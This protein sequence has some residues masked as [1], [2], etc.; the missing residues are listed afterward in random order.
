V[1]GK[2]ERPLV[3]PDARI[4]GSLIVSYNESKNVYRKPDSL[5]LGYGYT[6]VDTWL[7][8]NLG[9]KRAIENRAR[10]FVAVRYFDG[11]YLEAPDPIEVRDEIKY[12]DAR[13]V[14]SEFT[15]YRKYFYKTRYVYGFGRTEDIP[16]GISY[17]LTGGYLTLQ[18]L[19]RPYFALKVNAGGANEKGNFYTLNL[20]TG[21]FVRNQEMEDFVVMAGAAYYSRL[22]KLRR[23]HLRN[24]VSV[25]YTE[26]Y[27]RSIV[28]WLEVND[29][30]IPGFRTDS[31][32]ADRRFAVHLESTLYTPWSLL[33]FRFAPFTAIDMVPVRCAS[34]EESNPVFWGFSLGIRTRNEN[35]IFGT[36]EAKATLIPKDEFGDSRFEFSFKQNLRIKSSGSYVKAPSLIAYN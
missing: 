31:L 11:S 8:Y 30:E 29:A 16:A 15:H 9:I 32:Q 13:G 34:C 18:D 35:L 3:T 26:L 28:N 10:Q 22:L 14:L 4:A 2:I 17:G 20:E 6:R 7:G 23:Y 1:Y 25:T 21:G 33:G 12:H 27:N 24:L 5:F 19:E 36:I